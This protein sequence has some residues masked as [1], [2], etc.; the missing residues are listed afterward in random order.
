MNYFRL[1]LDPPCD[2]FAIE[3]PLEEKPWVD[4]HTWRVDDN[5]QVYRE[6]VTGERVLLYH[7]ILRRGTSE[8]RDFAAWPLL[9]EDSIN[10]FFQ[11][12]PE[13]QNLQ[14]L[15]AELEAVCLK[16]KLTAPDFFEFMGLLLS[17]ALREYF[18]WERAGVHKSFEPDLTKLTPGL[19]ISSS[20]EDVRYTVLYDWM[21]GEYYDWHRAVTA[22][23]GI[24]A[25][26]YNEHI[27]SLAR[28]ILMDGLVIENQDVEEDEFLEILQF[29]TGGLF[30][31]IITDAALT[32]GYYSIPI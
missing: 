12:L 8:D 6:D 13:Y 5:G 21:A 26:T 22:P 10:T 14:E 29:N 7:E 31:G 11:G 16:A 17:Q 9:E 30:A 15:W 32:V 2:E 4:Q 23:C 18:D 28:D 24:A 20:L 19:I 1:T 25:I 27:V 3:L